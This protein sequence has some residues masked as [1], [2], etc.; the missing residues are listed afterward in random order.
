MEVELKHL[1]ENFSLA[2]F[3]IFGTDF[4]PGPTHAALRQIFATVRNKKMID[5]R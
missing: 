1:K 5:G 2:V 4:Y 3:R